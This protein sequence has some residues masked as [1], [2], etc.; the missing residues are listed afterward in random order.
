MTV[1]KHRT[2]LYRHYNHRLYYNFKVISKIYRYVYYGST[3]SKL[4]CYAK[5]V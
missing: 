4:G 1:Q 5:V 3:Y 2:T